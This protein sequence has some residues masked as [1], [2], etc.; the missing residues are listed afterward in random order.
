MSKKNYYRGKTRYFG[1]SVKTG[2]SWPNLRS[3]V[4]VEVLHLLANTEDQTA[5]AQTSYVVS[6]SFD[7]F[8]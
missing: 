7:Q 3:I 1:Q 6:A 5:S 4:I 2:F 8:K